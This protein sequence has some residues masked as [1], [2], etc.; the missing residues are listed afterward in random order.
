VGRAVKNNRENMMRLRLHSM[1]AIAGAILLIPSP[2]RTQQTSSAPEQQKPG[3]QV[4]KQE[5]EPQEKT[6]EAPVEP[7][8]SGPYP[9]MSK[10][11]EER[12][13]EIFEMFNH[14]QTT[15]MWTALSDGLRK[16]SGKEERFVEINKK[17]RET[18][19][20]E[21]KVIEE[22]MVPYLMA[23]DTV[24][25]RLSSFGNV[26]VP[27]ILTITF[28]QRGQIDAFAINPMHTIAEGR[29]AGYETKA[30]LKLP[31]NGEWLVYHGGRNIFQ[32]PYSMSDEMRFS[33]DFVY[34]KNGKLFSG[35][36]GV[37]SKNE[38][39]YCFG[40]PIL[41][42]ADGTVVKAVS[43]YDDNPPG[44]PTGDPADGNV[45]VISHG[46]GESSMMNHLKQ[47]SLKVKLDDKVKQG[48]VIAECGNSGAG[49]IP[50]VHYQLQR[51][52]SVGLPA[53]FVDY[54]ADGK[55]VASGEFKRGQ[56]VKNGTT[57]TAGTAASTTPTK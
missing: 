18:M 29:F 8:L 37:G 20:P 40:Q 4:G 51:T 32:N 24:Y 17:L 21:T 25:S 39:Y 50:Y 44:K 9:V 53:Q 26:R 12:G 14:T 27:V 2:A 23:P 5:A 48:D 3:A 30:K 45:I 7:V 57:A 38:D 15:A 6:A 34:V 19:G 35:R 54:V 10:A 55:P 42:P 11:A 56:M 22:N 28:N 47:N 49:P 16:M 33:L 31:F 43:G 36:G 1:I 13:R 52:P 46:N 41:A